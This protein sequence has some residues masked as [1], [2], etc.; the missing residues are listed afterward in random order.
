MRQ[1]PVGISTSPAPSRSSSACQWSIHWREGV[2]PPLFPRHL[3]IPIIHS[4]DGRR[5]V[6]GATVLLPSAPAVDRGS[7]M[8]PHQCPP[9]PNVDARIIAMPPT[10]RP[11]LQAT[12]AAAASQ[13]S[14]ASSVDWPKPNTRMQGQTSGCWKKRSNGGSR[15]MRNGG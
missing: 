9:H 2:H 13:R 7:F 15:K 5:L 4:V 8:G 6:N 12:E 10:I 11:M 1:T 3:S 14:T